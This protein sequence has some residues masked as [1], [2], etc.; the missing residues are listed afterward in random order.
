V[1][2]GL[3]VTVYETDYSPRFYTIDC[4]MTLGLGDTADLLKHAITTTMQLSAEQRMFDSQYFS[5]RREIS[6][7]IGQ[8]FIATVNRVTEARTAGRAPLIVAAHEVAHHHQ[9]Q[10]QLLQ[11]LTT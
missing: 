10:H 11:Q 9:Q 8:V 3:K 7:N 6:W 4:S 5:P 1:N 2:R